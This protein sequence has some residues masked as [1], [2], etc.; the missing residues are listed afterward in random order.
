MAPHLI[1]SVLAVTRSRP[2]G[3]IREK[4]RRTRG[5]EDWHV[6]RTRSPK[7]PT[8]I[9]GGRCWAI[10]GELSWQQQLIAVRPYVDKSGTGRCHLVLH[11]GGAS[12]TAAGRVP[13]LALSRREGRT[14]RPDRGAW[15]QGHA[16][17]M[18]REL[19]V[20]LL[21]RPVALAGDA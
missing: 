21:D 2:R 10:R 16:E 18:R 1:S 19:R 13:G 11:Q 5:E 9:D 20:G 7:K 3:L 4:R 14:T 12:Q 8:G 6:H 15:R 17:A